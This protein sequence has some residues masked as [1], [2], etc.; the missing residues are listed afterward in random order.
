MSCIL[1]LLLIILPCILPCMFYNPHEELIGESPHVEPV[2]STYW[3][4]T[5]TG[6]LMKKKRY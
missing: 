4:K 1:N 3:E 5:H 2:G 6:D